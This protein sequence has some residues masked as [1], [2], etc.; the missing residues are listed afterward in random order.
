MKKLSI[1]VA[2]VA[3]MGTA[4]FAQQPARQGK[5]GTKTE[6]VAKKHHPKK[7]GAKSTGMHKH[8]TVHKTA[9]DSSAVKP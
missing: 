9:T 7:K 1:A 2:L 6:Q 8:H 4:A 3:L 5:A